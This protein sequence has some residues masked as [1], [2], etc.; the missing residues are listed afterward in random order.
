MGSG[1]RQDLIAAAKAAPGKI[2]YSSGGP[3]SP[4]HLAMAMFASKAG[5]SLT[6]VPYKGAAYPEKHQ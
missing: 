1:C 6:H 4:Q 5:I 3:G 2:D